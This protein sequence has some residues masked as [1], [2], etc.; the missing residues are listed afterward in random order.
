MNQYVW[1]IILVKYGNCNGSMCT[2]FYE[3]EAHDIMFDIDHQRAHE[4]FDTEYG[5]EYTW[6]RKFVPVDTEEQEHNDDYTEEQKLIRC[7]Q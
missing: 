2:P 3:E 4:F 1:K 5:D 7:K 6:E